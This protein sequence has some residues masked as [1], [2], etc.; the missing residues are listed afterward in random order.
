[1]DPATADR[2]AAHAAQLV[3]GFRP[4]SEAEVDLLATLLRPSAQ[5]QLA[6]RRPPRRPASGA[7]AA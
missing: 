6:G 5:R 4:L 1:L 3:A 2:I 7:S